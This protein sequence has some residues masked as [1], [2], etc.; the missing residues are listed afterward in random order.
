M[1][2]QLY[3]DWDLKQ[4]LEFTYGGCEG[5]VNNFDSIEECEVFCPDEEQEGLNPF[6]LPAEIGPCKST[7]HQVLL[8][9][10]IE[11]VRDIYMWRMPRECK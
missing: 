3:Y 9:Q 6:E 7:L 1:Q 2:G 4:C 11:E 8:Q 10:R 5:N